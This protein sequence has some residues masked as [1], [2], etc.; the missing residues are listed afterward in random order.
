MPGIPRCRAYVCATH[1]Q[2]ARYSKRDVDFIA[3]YLLSEDAWYIIPLR[4]IPGREVSLNPRFR[5]N[6][7]RQYREAWDLLIPERRNR[8]WFRKPKPARQNR[9]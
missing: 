9:K 4:A 8:R 6:K 1:R 5:R 2:G 7:Y 3:A